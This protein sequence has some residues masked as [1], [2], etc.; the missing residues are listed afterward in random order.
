VF[1][2][3]LCFDSISNIDLIFSNIIYRDDE[4]YII[5][6]E[7]VFECSLPVEYTLYRTLKYKTL[8]KE[9]K[10]LEKYENLE[11]FFIFK[12]VYNKSFHKYNFKYIKKRMILEEVVDKKEQQIQANEQ[13]LQKL[14]ITLN[15]VEQDNQSLKFELESAIILNDGNCF[16]LSINLKK[17]S[18]RKIYMY[19]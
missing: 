18:Y 5:D 2:G 19:L 3:E 16:I 4:I 12:Y 9:Y 6:Y 1:D 15:N 11:D 14:E 17:K 8:L 13:Q 10:Y 7:W